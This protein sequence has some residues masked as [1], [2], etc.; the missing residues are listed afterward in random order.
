[1]LHQLKLDLGGQL[2]AQAIEF[3]EQLPTAEASAGSN[4][5]SAK[6][7]QLA[8][9]FVSLQLVANDTS[10]CS[11]LMHRL[12]QSQLFAS[13]KLSSPLESIEAQSGALRFTLRCEF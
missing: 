2:H 4:S 7:N 6:P 1:M 3:A 10:A 11:D 9:G 12:K 5:T 8:H 13:V